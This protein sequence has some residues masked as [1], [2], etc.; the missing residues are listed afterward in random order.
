MEA[1][2]HG[3]LGEEAFPRPE[4]GETIVLVQQFHVS[5][6]DATQQIE[7]IGHRARRIF[8]VDVSKY[9]SALLFAAESFKVIGVAGQHQPV[10]RRGFVNNQIRDPRRSARPKNR[11]D[12]TKAAVI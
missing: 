5:E 12:H 7:L 3:G 2:G 11:N 8:A 1:L 10:N 9:L 4:R 6:A